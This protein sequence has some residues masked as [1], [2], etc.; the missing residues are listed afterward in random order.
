M[1]RARNFFESI[2]FWL[3]SHKIVFALSLLIFFGLLYYVYAQT[4][5]EKGEEMYTVKMES[6]EQAVSL[7]G[8]VKPTQEAQLSFEKSGVVKTLQVKVGD[9]V[10][11]G[12]ILATLSSDDDLV[13]VAEARAG[14]S[15]AVAS[16]QDSKTGSKDDVVQI[17]KITLEKSKNDVEQAYKN[18]GDSVHNL[19]ISGNSFVRDNMA[20]YFDGDSISG[21]R[22]NINSCDSALENKL[23]ILR[24]EADISLVNIENTSRDFSSKDLSVKKQNIDELK[25]ISAPKI[26][27][28]LNAWKDVLSLGCMTS[29]S[30]FDTAR[31]LVTSSRN[32]WSALSNDIS[33]KRNTIDSAE[34]SVTQAEKDLNLSETGEKGEKVSQADS[35]VKV[36]Q[37]RLQSAQVVLDKNILRA[38]FTGIITNIDLKQGE[39][40]TVGARTISMISDANF[41]IESKV[42]EVDVAKLQ[43]GQSA[44]VTFDAYGDSEKFQAIISNISLAGI[45]SEGVPTYKTIFDFLEKD[46]RVRSGMTA[47]ILVTTKKLDNVLAI[48]VKYILEENGQ[49]YVNII[50]KT[51]EKRFIKTGALGVNAKVEVVEGLS[52]GEVVEIEK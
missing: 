36:A 48:P 22:V 6:L 49:K 20:K 7:T 47:N 21:Y 39:F 1:K 23:N 32:T 46:E 9:K 31:S 2:W 52:E 15:S 29:N 5:A 41:Q 30:T 51:K 42:S 35:Q 4:T 44:Q 26:S 17:K 33:M 10:N 14:L 19:A 43:T 13:K 27:E 24:K 16:L 25:N 50:G 18:A 12:Q 45:I 40:Q 8:A 34:L 3:Q 37:A 28:Y 38:P 11:K